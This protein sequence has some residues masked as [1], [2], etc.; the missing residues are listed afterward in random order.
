MQ[1]RAFLVFVMVLPVF[2]LYVSLASGKVIYNSTPSYPTGL[3]FVEQQSAYTKGELVLIC[4]DGNKEFEIKNKGY[5]TASTTHCTN[6]FAPLI[7]KIVANKND[8]VEVT[9]AGVY[10][11]KVKQSKSTILPQVEACMGLHYLKD[12]AIWVMSDFN[13]ASFDSRYFCELSINK[14]IGKVRFFW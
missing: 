10:I 5:V 11:N 14:I 2:I 9:Q 13:S 12:D 7:K 8:V 4:A 1:S 6:G 3:Y